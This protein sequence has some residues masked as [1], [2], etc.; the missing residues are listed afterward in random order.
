MLNHQKHAIILVAST[1]FLFVQWSGMR[2]GGSKLSTFF[3][4][5]Q[6]TNRRGS[7]WI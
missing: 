7:L 1:A 4:A 6:R 2:S 5:L 3:F